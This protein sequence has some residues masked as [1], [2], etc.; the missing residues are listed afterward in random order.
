MTGIEITFPCER[1]GQTVRTGITVEPGATDSSAV[2]SLIECANCGQMNAI[3]LDHI[4]RTRQ[5]AFENNRKR[6]K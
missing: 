6:R 3:E 1:C 5:A 4:W 2:G